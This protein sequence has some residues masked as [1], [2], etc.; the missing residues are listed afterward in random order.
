MKIRFAVLVMLAL[1][2]AAEARAADALDQGFA[3]PPESTK[4]WCY[5]YWISD[6]ISR[7]GITRDLEAM[8]R[9]GIGE[10]LIGNIYL[11]DVKVGNVK[12]L[13]EE[14]WGM[15][16]H[17]VR[18]GGR[19]GVNIG[20]FNCPGWSQSGG[21]WIQPHQAMRYL[22]SAERRVR[23]PSTFKEKLEK[24]A[25]EFQDVAVLAFRVPA[26]EKETLTA[27][28]AKV[29]ATPTMG[30]ADSLIDG[31]RET[32]V[33]FPEG[34]GDKPLV[35]ELE[36][37]EPIIARSL[38][39][40]PAR[41]DFATRCELSVAGDDGAF[42]VIRSFRID[43]SNNG[44]AVGF[45]PHAPVAV[46]FPPTTGKKFRLSFTGNSGQ[47]GL[48]EIEL[49][50]AAKV[51]R[52]M[53]KQLAKMYPTPLPL[54]NA[55]LWPATAEPGE[56]KQ[57]LNPEEVRDLTRRM[58]QDGTLHWEVPEGDWVIL[59]TG[60]TPTGT[61]NSPASP[62]GQGLEVDK[63][64]CSAVQG[65]YEAY[66]GA[67]LQRLP[68]AER[69]AF[70]H[71]V[72]DSYEMGS[73][74]WTDGLRDIFKRRYG[75]DPQPWLPVLTGRV[76]GS[77]DQSDRFLWD[78]RRLV[79]D[80][81]AYDY[82]GCL[83]EA[84]HQHDLRLWL[85]N[86]GHWGFPGEFLQ[87]GGQS[88]DVSGEFWATGDLGSIELRAAA[89]AAHTYGKPIVSAEA[90][91]S[92]QKF[93]ATP[94]SLKKRG[95]WALT[96]GINHWVLHVYIHQPWE[97]RLPGVNAWFSTEFNRHNTWFDQGR[98]WIDYYRRCQFLLQQGKHVADV[99]YFIGED[100]PKMTG[101]R[102]PLLPAGH[103]FDYIN[104]EV[105]MKR[106][107]AENGRF[108]LPDGM[109]YRVLV[110]P[111][112]DTMRPELLMKLRDL[113]AA[114]GVI[115][116]APPFRSPSLKGYPAADRSVREIA[117][118]LWKDCDG[119]SRT[120]TTFGRGKVFRNVPLET[121]FKRLEIP[122]D[123]GSSATKVLWT[124]RATPEA[125]IYF[126]SN[127]AETP[128]RIAP[129]FRVTNKAP[130]LWDAVSAR[131]WDAPVFE[132]TKD[133]LRVAVDLEPRGSIF[134][135]FR[136]PLASQ[137][138][139]VAISQGE[140]RLADL[141]EPAAST[142][143][144]AGGVRDRTNNFSMAGWARPQAGIA[145]PK[146]ADEGV[147]INLERNDAI[148]AVHGQSAFSDPDH[149]G[150]G[151]SI[152]TNGIA[153]YE[154]SGNY[155][156]PLLVHQHPVNGWTH[157]AVIYREGRPHLYLNGKSA[158]SGRQSRYH[159]HSSFSFG[160][161]PN[162]D[163]KGE[164]AGFQEFGGA[165]A[166][167]EVA[168]L[169]ANRPEDSSRFALPAIAL[170]FD[171]NGKLLANLAEA[172]PFT[173]EMANEKKLKVAAPNLP[174][175]LEVEGEWTVRFPSGRDVPESINMAALE[176]L[177]GHTNEA[178]RFFAGT[179]I[180]GKSIQLPAERLANGDRLML[181]LGR[182]ESLAEVVV[183][184]RD[185]GIFWKPPFVVDITAV[186]RA[187]DNALEIRITGTWR[188]RLIGAAK[189]PNG[190]RGSNNSVPEFQPY[191]TADLKLAPDS[192]LTPFGLIGPVQVRSVRSVS[193]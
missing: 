42:K 121:V 158:H 159:V 70:K 99:A 54:W 33:L 174:A 96:E 81:V 191:T 46:S 66:I 123:F 83:R 156:A 157:V 95:D 32:E 137:P 5:W 55:Y 4:P 65:H 182:V 18:E 147:F 162:P 138:S 45:V 104:A 94:W 43:R 116:G 38:V 193:P 7:E 102:K 115:L 49:S 40:V 114:G 142:P 69:K 64:N 136:K 111:E 61:K 34:L 180:Y 71:V 75:Y 134:V 105:I 56:A 21:P 164:L 163:F 176:S 181:D 171:A 80:Q 141:K 13:S 11:D 30:N 154:H 25:A 31:R 188:N 19:I 101:V 79:A 179:A 112:G 41:K 167:A 148:V 85:E 160:D 190:V 93:E 127:Q 126:L 88:D 77:G 125:D 16:E 68:R 183:N 27:H 129:V 119:E 20:F 22:A 12:A 26:A 120:E 91:T 9:V 28:G 122:P 37:E 39:L 117:G 170:S 172:G 175:P 59:R 192:A 29:S 62:Q 10:A 1:C 8:K 44:I 86:Y 47:A 14:W 109:S 57:A 103:N 118:E 155:F 161:G 186:A 50:G 151:I 131:T 152:G 153:V 135:V 107:A 144:S 146:E 15:V 189:Y 36:L 177:T 98:E 130:E 74:N 97:D 149:S 24:P 145:L 165:L 17:A 84:A 76:V 168:R 173:I 2:A 187:G 89:S 67:L 124:H 3:N 139:V 110:L 90:F 35:I 184:G 108:V 58:T 132:N 100:V 53:E 48:G 78:L 128:A 82:V 6:N 150:A 143:D 133:G 87:Y 23:G 113:V 92:T 178:I 106:L 169:A 140:K 60:M 63:M 73:Q 166:E 51:E 52:Y 185:L 72:A